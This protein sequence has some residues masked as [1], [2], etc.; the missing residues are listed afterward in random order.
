[1]SKYSIADTL[2]IYDIV[3]LPRNG[4]REPIGKG[5]PGGRCDGT[6]PALGLNKPFVCIGDVLVP[7]TPMED[8]REVSLEFAAAFAAAATA[9]A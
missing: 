6:I 7:G 3:L 9:I 1:M 8:D 4:G 2:V 5:K